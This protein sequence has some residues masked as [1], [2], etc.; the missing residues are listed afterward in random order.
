MLMASTTQVMSV[1]QNS[2]E[3]VLGVNRAG[4]AGAGFADCLRWGLCGREGAPVRTG[5][6][7]LQ[8][9]VA[10]AHCIS[11]AAAGWPA[12]QGETFSV[13]TE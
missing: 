3:P 8:I 5:C 11:G 9:S 4:R 12:Q 6:Q 13:R 2:G 7:Q 10:V 1:W